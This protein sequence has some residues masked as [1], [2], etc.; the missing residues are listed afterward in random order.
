ML[1]DYIKRD[2]PEYYDPGKS[3]TRFELNVIR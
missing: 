3:P 2:P 1:L